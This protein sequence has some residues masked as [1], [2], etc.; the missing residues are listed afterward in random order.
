MEGRNEEQLLFPIFV[1]SAEQ[2]NDS[3]FGKLDL[4]L[5]KKAFGN[6]PFCFCF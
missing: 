5:S 2:E 3:Q 4:I 1:M 6:S